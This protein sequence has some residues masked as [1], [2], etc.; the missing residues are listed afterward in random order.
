MFDVRENQSLNITLK[1]SGYPMPVDYN[2]LDPL[3]HPLPDEQ[4]HSG[5]LIFTNIQ[6]IHAGIYQCFASNSV[7]KTAVNIHL[8]V[9]C[10]SNRRLFFLSRPFFFLLTSKMDQRSFNGKAMN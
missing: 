9:L 6:K 8:N 10:K 7:G 3:G 5:Q 2:C 4:C 1:A